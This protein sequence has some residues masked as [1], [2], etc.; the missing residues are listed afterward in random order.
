MMCKYSTMESR[1][2]FFRYEEYT[3]FHDISLVVFLSVKGKIH[4][5]YYIF[6]KFFL[7]S[8]I[9]NSLT[10]SYNFCVLFLYVKRSNYLWFLQVSNH[11]YYQV[12]I[13]KYFPM[14]STFHV[15]MYTCVYVI[16][17]TRVWPSYFPHSWL[18]TPV[19]LS[20]LVSPQDQRTEKLYIFYPFSFQTFKKY[21]SYCLISF[22]IMYYMDLRLILVFYVLNFWYV[23][24]SMCL[25]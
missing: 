22:L 8:F 7:M 19:C 20:W 18:D 16:S 6:F 15:L 23:M 2:P 25:M 10:I 13:D 12:Y 3:R 4:Q 21:I 14:H 1:F 11:L 17:W 24:Y 5:I 9:P